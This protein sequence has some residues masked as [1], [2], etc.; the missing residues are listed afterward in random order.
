MVPSV[1][2]SAFT[3]TLAT[4][5]PLRN[6]PRPAMASPMKIAAGT[7]KPAFFMSA[8]VITPI[9]EAIAPT[10]RSNTPLTI[11]SIMPSA[12]IP[13]KAR[14]RRMAEKLSKE[15]NDTGNRTEY[16]TTTKSV[17]SASASSRENKTLGIGVA[18]N[19]FLR[20]FG[21]TQLAIN[22]AGAHHENAIG[23]REHFRKIGG[24]DD[25]RGALACQFAQQQVH[26]G[27]GAYV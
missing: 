13:S 20:G 15:R 16:K 3:R 23:H 12:R 1:V 8:P 21:K 10:E 14:L 27:F 24:D 6:P 18:H 7:G 4:T 11:M 2:I 17:I 25:H 9:I 22:A 26:F 19:A 5:K